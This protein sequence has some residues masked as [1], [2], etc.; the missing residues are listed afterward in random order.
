MGERWRNCYKEVGPF[1][2]LVTVQFT[3]VGVN[4]LFKEATVK[5]L[6]YYVFIFYSFTLSTLILLLPLPFIFRRSTGLPSLN[7]SLICKISSLGL[8]AFS[9]Q[10]CGYKGIDL[11]SPTLASAMA[12]LLPAFTFILA[13]FFRFLFPFLSPFILFTK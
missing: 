11:S 9:A 8:L 1:C 6:S 4:V 3:E 2:A 12:N 13:V 7:F 10:V 5:G